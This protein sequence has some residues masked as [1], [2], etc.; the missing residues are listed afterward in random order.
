MFVDVGVIETRFDIIITSIS[1][2]MTLTFYSLALSKSEAQSSFNAKIP[3]V[4]KS[5]RYRKQSLADEK[6]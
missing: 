1:M 6:S 3:F 4:T 5:T 2:K